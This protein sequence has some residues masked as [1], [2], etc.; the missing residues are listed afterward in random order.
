MLRRLELSKAMRVLCLARPTFHKI[1]IIRKNGG[2]GLA[3]SSKVSLG[4]LVNLVNL[5]GNETVRFAVHPLGGLI[6][7]L[8]D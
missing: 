6:T 8:F 7:L 1:S 4:I 3:E 2:L 5:A